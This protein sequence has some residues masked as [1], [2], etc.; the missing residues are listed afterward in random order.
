MTGQNKQGGK[1]TI[2]Q[3]K[4]AKNRRGDRRVLEKILN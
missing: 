1:E 4:A 3:D 2:G